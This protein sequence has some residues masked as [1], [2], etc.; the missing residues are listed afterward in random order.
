MTS[1]VKHK[2]EVPETLR[3][4]EEWEMFPCLWDASATVY[5]DRNAKDLAYSKIL[6]TINNSF[7]TKF[8]LSDI[9]NRIHCIRS[10]YQREVRKINASKKSGSGSDDL[11]KPKLYFFA[12]LGFLVR[13]GEIRPTKS[14]QTRTQGGGGIGHGRPPPFSLRSVKNLRK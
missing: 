5:R 4:I 3:L 14:T 9:K 1:S 13:D 12:R 8:T 10:Q 2:W 6:E 11:H 7:Q